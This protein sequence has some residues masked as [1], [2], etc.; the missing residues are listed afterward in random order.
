M[1][2]PPDA[3]LPALRRGLDPVPAEDEG[4]PLFL[5]RDLEELSETTLGLSPAGMLLASL[6]DGKRNAAEVGAEFAKV[7]GQ[8][9]KPEQVLELAGQLERALLLETPA[10]AAR[11]EAVLRAFRESPTR[12]A[13]FAGAGYPAAP[14]EL[15]GLLTG[16]YNDPKGPGKEPPAGPAAQAP[17][18]LVSPHIDFA[19]GG[20][21]YA[22]AYQALAESRPPD[23]IVALGVA[24]RS[25]DS[26]WVL[27]RKAYE[28]PYGAMA[29]DESLYQ[30]VSRTLWYDPLAD[31]D[32]HR[33]EHSLEFQAVWLRHLW[34]EKTPPWLPILCSSFERF[35]PDA[36]PSTVPAVERALVA[37]GGLLR[38]RAQAGRRVLVLAGVDL[39]HVGPRFGDEKDV[40]PEREKEVEAADRK[41]LEHA[42]ALDADAF[43]LSV[44]AD[45][46]ARR[47]CGLSALYTSLRL[48][49]ALGSGKEAGRLLTY[50]QALDPAGG[51]VSFAS[52]IF[53]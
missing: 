47:V 44:V 9:V 51:V 36:P 27:T 45:G 39:A 23:L 42:L 48:I 35:C 52:A 26:P 50:G 20:P 6:F 15:S 3:P 41:S 53:P 8:R 14:V 22:W 43:Y 49:K 2:F 33:K 25:P 34:G 7:S 24:H 30:D 13:A 32:V 40:T 12:K 16:F 17:L 18:G 1:S 29:L 19:R 21:A 38:A 46:H 31:E 10:T 37:L 11:R 4:R 5:L 28:T